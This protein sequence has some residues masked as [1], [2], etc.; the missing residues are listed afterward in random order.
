MSEPIVVFDRVSKGYRRQHLKSFL[1]RELWPGRSLD[2]KD[3]DLFWAL[4]D[5]SFRVQSG[6]SVAIFGSNGSGKST[7]LRL[8]AGASHPSEGRVSVAGRVAPVLALGVGF[9]PDMTASENAYLN[10]ALLGLSREELE[11]RLPDILSFAALGDFDDVP[12]RH[13]SSGMLARLGF[14]VAMH[15]DADVLLIDEVLA[16]GD[17]AFQRKC[18]H[19]IKTLQEQGRTLLIATHDMAMAR[20]LCDRALWIRAGELEADG[21]LA[22]VLEAYEGALSAGSA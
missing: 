17:G 2:R 12:V 9:E 16:V 14:G 21:P 19:R 8:V 11:T 15:I 1:L 5:V 20:E 4:R 22:E 10:A 7:T 3:S 18:L 13:Y 6:E